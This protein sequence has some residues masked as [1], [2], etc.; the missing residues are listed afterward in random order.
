[1][2]A[3]ISS[4]ANKTMQKKRLKLRYGEIAIV[5]YLLEI[6]MKLSTIKTV[7]V[8]KL[9]INR[10]YSLFWDFIHVLNDLNWTKHLNLM[11]TKA[12]AVIKVSEM[13]I[14]GLRGGDI[15]KR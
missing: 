8:F 10:K 7:N 12:S 3:A 6:P 5:D 13:E 9:H 11:H 14:A 15:R 2:R 1:M 4:F